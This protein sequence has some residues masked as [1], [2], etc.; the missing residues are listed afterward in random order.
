MGCSCTFTIPLPRHVVS[1]R[2][3][4]LSVERSVRNNQTDH[5][6]AVFDKINEHTDGAVDS[7]GET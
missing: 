2:E 7:C 6:L 3:Q 5:Q 4:E 1:V